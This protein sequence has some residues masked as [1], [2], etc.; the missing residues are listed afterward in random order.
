MAKYV[1]IK[2]TNKK[3]KELSGGEK[4]RVALA[5]IIAF[6]PDYLILDEPTVGLDYQS[7]ENLI[8]ILM[9]LKNIL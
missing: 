1:Y 2:K 3:V 9:K 6:K 4:R 7:Q 8:N 5:G